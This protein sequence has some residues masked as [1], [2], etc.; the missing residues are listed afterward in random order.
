MEE[1]K[2]EVRYRNQCI[3]R[4]MSIEDALLFVKAFFNEHREE[5][6]LFLS[7]NEEPLTAESEGDNV[8]ENYL[9]YLF[10]PEFGKD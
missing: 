7:V 4:G 10:G 1:R 6:G 9:R 2:Y 3:S 8:T 5:R